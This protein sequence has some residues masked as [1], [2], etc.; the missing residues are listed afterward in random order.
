MTIFLWNISLWNEAMSEKT[1]AYLKTQQ[2]ISVVT[3]KIDYTLKIV[4]GFLHYFPHRFVISC[5]VDHWQNVNT[6][7]DYF[8]SSTSPVQYL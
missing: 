4:H 6:V 1:V 5:M 7:C 8:V 2:L 3:A